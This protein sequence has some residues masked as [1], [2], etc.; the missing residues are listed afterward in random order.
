MSRRI[1]QIEN[2]EKTYETESERL[3]ILKDLNFSAEAGKKISIVGQSGSGKSTFLNILGG[4]DAPTAGKVVC[5]D[6]D[7]T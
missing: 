2:L 5:G 1:V 4:L 6:F 3:T 7:L